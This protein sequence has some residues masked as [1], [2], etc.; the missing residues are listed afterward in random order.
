MKQGDREY[1]RPGGR[2]GWAREH[3]QGRTT[4]VAGTLSPSMAIKHGRETEA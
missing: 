1:I 2:I 3:S 4:S